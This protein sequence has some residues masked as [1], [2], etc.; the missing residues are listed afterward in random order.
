MKVSRK[1]IMNVL[2][3]VLEGGSRK[4]TRILD[5]K[6]KVTATR[7][8]KHGSVLLSIGKPNYAERIHIKQCRSAGIKFT[9]MICRAEK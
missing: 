5:I 8:R 4:A 6:T 9:R 1:A 3:A 2:E 7:V